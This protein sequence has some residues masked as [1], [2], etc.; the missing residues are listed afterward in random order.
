MEKKGRLKKEKRTGDKKIA[1]QITDSPFF[2]SPSCFIFSLIGPGGD[3][4]IEQGSVL[5]QLV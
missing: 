1:R 5:P 2:L 3:R 4:E